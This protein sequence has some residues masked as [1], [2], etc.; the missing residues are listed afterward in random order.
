MKIIP[1]NKAQKRRGV[2]KNAPNGSARQKGL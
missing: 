1:M 2:I